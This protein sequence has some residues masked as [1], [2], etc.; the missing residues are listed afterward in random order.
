MGLRFSVRFLRYRRWLRATA[1]AF[2]LCT[3]IVRFL[4]Q[5]LGGRP[6]QSHTEAAR[7]LYGNSEISVQLP[8]TLRILRTE[9]SVRFYGYCTGSELQR[10]DSCAR[11]LRLSQK[12]IISVRLFWPQCPPKILRFLDDQHAASARCPCRDCAM[13]HTTCLRAL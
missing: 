6:G 8:C 7:R 1:Y 5:A 13:P 4:V 3:S 12:P 11:T 2:T 10:C 9:I